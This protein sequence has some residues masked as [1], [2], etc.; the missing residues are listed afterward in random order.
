MCDPGGKSQRIPGAKWLAHWMFSMIGVAHCEGYDCHAN[1]QSSIVCFV[2]P[3]KRYSN[4]NP[5]NKETSSE[6]TSRCRHCR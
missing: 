3:A 6:S 5:T 4:S 1:R 2:N